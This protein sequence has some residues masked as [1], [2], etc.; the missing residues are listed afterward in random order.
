MPPTVT[1]TGPVTAP[2]GTVV[3]I[4]VLLQVVG[5]AGVPLKVI[6]LLPCVEPKKF[7]TTVTVVP[8]GPSIGLV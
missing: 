4:C 7:P 2:L 6:V 3:T 5:V 1:T 8:T